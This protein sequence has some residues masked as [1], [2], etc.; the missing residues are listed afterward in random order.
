[1]KLGVKVEQMK[2][3]LIRDMWLT[4][5]LWAESEV[6]SFYHWY[7]RIYLLHR[8]FAQRWVVSHMSPNKNLLWFVLFTFP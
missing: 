8:F 7:M 4:T 1:M 6:Q 3:F 5:I 2:P